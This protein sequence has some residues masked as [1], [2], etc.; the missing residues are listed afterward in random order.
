MY[1]TY[2]GLL[3]A[4][5]LSAVL[6]SFTFSS[7]GANDLADFTFANG[8]EPKSLDPH[9]MTGVLEGRIAD[10]LFEG[11]TYRGHDDLLAQPGSA[12]SW[13]ASPDGRTYVFHLRKEAR[14]SD[15][16]PVVAADFVYSWKRLQEPETASEYAY[17]LHGIRHA[18]AYNT[19][20]AQVKALRGDPV[21]ESS[22]AR[23][24]ILAGL[25][26]LLLTAPDGLPA[27][28][29]QAFA[30]ARAIRDVVI[31]PEERVVV[32]GF[33]RREGRFSP[34]E[35][36]AL[37]AGLGAEADRR[38]AALAAAKAH[39]G[40]DEGIYARDAMTFVVEL[41]AFI[42][43]FLDLTSFHAA[44]P[45]PRPAVEAHPESWFR[46]PDTLVC[47]GPFRMKRW[48]EN[49]AIRLERSETYWGKADVRLRTVD[50]LST[51][52]NQTAWSLYQTGACDWL[53]GNYPADLIDMLKQ[54]P[55]FYATPSISTYFYRVNT[56]RKPFD[57][58]HVRLALAK[59][60]DRTLLV[61][62]VT[63]KGEPIAL[64]ISP[65]GTGGGYEPPASRMGFDP[66]AA[67]AELA[68]AGFPGGKGFPKI[69]LLY[70]TS[71]GHKKYAEFVTSQW[72]THLQIDANAFNSEWKA[73]LQK[74][75]LLDYEVCRA[76]W[77]A[78]YNDPNTF[79]DMWVTKGGN[80]NTGW[81]DPFYD[82]LVSLASDPF[83]VLA[84]A[85]AVLAKC[86]EK[87][88]T[89]A[90]VER[91]RAAADGSDE[92]LAAAKALRFQLLREAEAILVQDAF[93]FI[94]IYFYVN[95]SLVSA[96]VQNFRTRLR[97]P[98][99][100]IVDNLQDLHPLRDLVVT[101]RR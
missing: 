7:G 73:Y 32:D 64:T 9:K 84:D 29:W 14:W 65:A 89:R 8:S 38:E 62:N 30:G 33:D 77:V 48:D 15:G 93:P 34:A 72:R 28:Q 94:P 50:I 51:D 6:V 40:V 16:R 87:D 79:L 83:R 81:G 68:K 42:P 36:T 86:K 101:E 98:D 69:A 95:T 47:N 1:R 49:R 74:Q 59:A 18:E 4:L 17:L 85:D 71:E 55:D 100:S 99:K 12:S 88:K 24:G 58:P 21:G 13:E 5:V 53:P 35:G 46:S 41:V 31:R 80:N 70:N 54:R 61:E 22:D 37:L 27:A 67:R 45:V 60:I 19:Y 23:E 44:L 2:L 11:L 75:T 52:N 82:R 91:L 43:Y 76:G 26:A 57:D 96:R 25:R 66:E 92:R 78:D 56:T 39:F 3:A 10:C 97:M 63:R 20:G 90:L